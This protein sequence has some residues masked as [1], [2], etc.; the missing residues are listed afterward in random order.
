MHV[1]P[2]PQCTSLDGPGG[3][4]TPPSPNCH[5]VHQP[6]NRPRHPIQLGKCLKMVRFEATAPRTPYSHFVRKERLKPSLTAGFRNIW[7]YQ[8]T[9]N[10]LFDFDSK[11][12]GKK[13][14]GFQTNRFKS[15]RIIKFPCRS[16]QLRPKS[17]Y[18]GPLIPLSWPLRALV[19]RSPGCHDE[20][21][22][23]HLKHLQSIDVDSRF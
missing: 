23:R 16:L 5:L 3:N 6:Q 7:Y 12:I 17:L 13:T 21:S 2:C 19:P 20:D 15:S 10:E 8:L 22:G 9:V 1:F 11:G 4:R 14:T 18:L